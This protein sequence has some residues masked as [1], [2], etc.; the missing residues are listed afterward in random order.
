MSRITSRHVPQGL[1]V[2]F[3]GLHGTEVG[4]LTPGPD[5]MVE[6]ACL[7]ELAAPIVGRAAD[8]SYVVSV[9]EGQ[10]LSHLPQVRFADELEHLFGDDVGGTANNIGPYLVEEVHVVLQE[11]EQ[12]ILTDDNVGNCAGVFHVVVTG[13]HTAL[14]RGL[15]DRLE[16]LLVDGNLN[17]HSRPLIERILL[18]WVDGEEHTIF[19]QRSS[20]NDEP[21][22][23]THDGK[24]VPQHGSKGEQ[25]I[26]KSQEHLPE[27]LVVTKQSPARLSYEDVRRP[28]RGQHEAKVRDE[29]ANV[30]GLPPFGA[31][32]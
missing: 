6:V 3:E 24:H 23:V 12:A 11:P 31:L 32:A 13:G 30:R 20:R 16:V 18:L 9:V 29:L 2:A 1:L 25:C 8:E 26:Q 21:E 10:P 15:N 17:R 5:G 4:H 28:R 19:L 7:L 14:Q 27:V 22:E